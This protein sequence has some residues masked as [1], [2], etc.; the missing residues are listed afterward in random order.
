MSRGP[1]RSLFVTWLTIDGALPL[2]APLAPAALLVLAAKAAMAIRQGIE[3]RGGMTRAI[4]ATLGIHT[5]GSLWLTGVVL[6]AA[7]MG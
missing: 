6:Y 1:M 7:F 4:E 2:A 3:D 5:V